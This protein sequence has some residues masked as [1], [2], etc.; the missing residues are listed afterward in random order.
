MNKF[1]FFGTINTKLE[2]GDTGTEVYIDNIGEAQWQACT[3]A[4]R[5]QPSYMIV[6]EP[7]EEGVFD[8]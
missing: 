8:F 7:L 2:A 5:M 4:L 3:I 1:S 6:E